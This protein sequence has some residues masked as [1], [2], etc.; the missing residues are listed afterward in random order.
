MNELMSFHQHEYCR[1]TQSLATSPSN[2]PHYQK[3]SP[4]SLVVK[5]SEFWKLDYY[6]ICRNGRIEYREIIAS[7]AN[8]NKRNLL[9]NEKY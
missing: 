2:L 3:S 6:T 9:I 8:N 7:K 4:N 5:I 1:I